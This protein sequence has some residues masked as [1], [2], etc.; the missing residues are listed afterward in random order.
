[1]RLYFAVLVVLSAAA[2]E[3]Q[4]RLQTGDRVLIE[5]DGR[6]LTGAVVSI[7]TD[8]LS[9][10][11]GGQALPVAYRDMESLDRWVRRPRGQGAKRGALIGAGVGAVAGGGLFVASIG[12]SHPSRVLCASQRF[13][14]ALSISALGAV[15]GGAPA[16]GAVAPRVFGL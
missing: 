8:T 15:V 3:A 9:V 4:P 10:T 2:V 11:G 14:T 12:R 13:T 5:I 16:R 6:T 7:A 1:M